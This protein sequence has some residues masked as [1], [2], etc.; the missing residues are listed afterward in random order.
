MTENQSLDFP[1]ELLVASGGT[2]SGA[3][4]DY[5]IDIK[6]QEFVYEGEEI[7]PILS[8]ENAPFSAQS[9][10]ELVGQTFSFPP[11]PEDGYLETSIYL[12]S[13]HNPIDVLNVHFGASESGG[14]EASFAMNFAFEYE[15]RCN[16]LQ[17]SITVFLRI[18]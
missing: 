15:G 18:K 17:K 14:I 7:N 13:V 8:I 6:M 9:I 12:W 1:G 16:N 2:I 3:D 10:E 4:N 5:A 11:N